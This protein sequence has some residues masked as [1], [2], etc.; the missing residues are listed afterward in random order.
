MSD[1]DN[2]CQSCG[3]CCAHYRVSFYWAEADDG[4]GATPHQMTE[5]LDAWSRCMRGTW[6]SRPRCCALRGE[7]GAA[8]ACD[9]YPQRP[10]PC[11]EVI[12]GSAQCAQARRCHGLP[13]LSPQ[14]ALA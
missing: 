11:R 3:A 4:G 12:A 5:K 2:P 9:I 14:P 7:I 10:T 6:S 8:V 1:Q 13:V